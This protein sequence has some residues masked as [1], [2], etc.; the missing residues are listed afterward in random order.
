MSITRRA[1]RGVAGLL[2]GGA[3]AFVELGYV[4]LGG[5]ALAL[6]A[7]RH[8]VLAGARLLAEFERHRLARFLGADNGDDY[9]GSRAMEYLLLRWLIGGLGAGIFLLVL[10]GAATAGVLAWQLVTGQPLGGAGSNSWYDPITY[11]LLGILLTFV[12]VQGLVGVATLDRTLARRMLGPSEAELLRRRV[13]ELATSRAEVLEAVNEERRR[14][15]RALHDG[16]QQRLVALGMLLGRAQ[17]STDPAQAER[18]LRQ[19]AEQ[20]KASLLD[21][22]EVSWQVYPIALDDGG[23]GAAVHAL[24]ERASVPV[25][26]RYEVP[27]RPDRAIETVAYYVVAEAVTNAAKHASATRIDIDIRQDT[28]MLVLVI[29]DDGAGGVRCPGG[30]DPRAGA[31]PGLSGLAGL[32]RRVAAADGTFTVDSPHGGPTVL[33]VE[34]PCG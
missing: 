1:A 3:S 16:V 13:S 28:A 11:V 12:T 5:A 26:V 34:L 8:R 9:T 32:D 20:S 18:L 21:L 17:R 14:I 29:R 24:A 22:R 2:I 6:P 15:E 4:L 10:A 7:V 23:L 19:A 31:V 25:R 33:R 30:A 27:A